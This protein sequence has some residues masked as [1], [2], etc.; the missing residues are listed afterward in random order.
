MIPIFLIFPTFGSLRTGLLY[1]GEWERDRAR[2][3]PPKSVMF[4]SGN[5]IK[6]Q[7]VLFLK[8]Q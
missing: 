4:K 1:Q 2:S 8:I 7:N 3:E 6:T 5:I